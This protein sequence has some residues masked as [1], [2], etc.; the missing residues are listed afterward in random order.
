VDYNRLR[1]KARALIKDYGTPV[2]LQQPSFSTFSPTLGRY[3]SNATVSYTVYAVIRTTG[4]I[5]TGDVYWSADTTI[6]AGDKEILIA[7]SD[8]VVPNVGD[9]LVV[10]GEPFKIVVVNAVRPGGTHLLYRVVIRR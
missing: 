2:V 6:E 1:L 8:A 5:W 3:T 9:G 7:T 4:R 10:D